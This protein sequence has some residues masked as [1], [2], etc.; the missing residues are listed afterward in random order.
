M[1]GE[2]FLTLAKNFNRFEGREASWEVFSGAEAWEV[3]SPC[4]K[5]WGLNKKREAVGLRAFLGVHELRSCRSTKYSGGVVW[6][7]RGWGFGVSFLIY[8]FISDCCWLRR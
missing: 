7:R 2:A 1:N 4:A 8:C 5:A 6:G 3:L